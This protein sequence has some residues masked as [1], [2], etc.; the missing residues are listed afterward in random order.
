M[1]TALC[2][3]IVNPDTGS[4]APIQHGLADLGVDSQVFRSA[5][6]FLASSELNRTGCA[7]VDCRLPELAG[8]E[9]M[10]KLT[11][12]PL[13]IP[14]IAT[15]DSATVTDAIRAFNAGVFAFFE[16]PLQHDKIIETAYKAVCAECDRRCVENERLRRLSPLSQ[17]ESEVLELLTQGKNVKAIARDLGISA[18]TVEKHRASAL[19][20]CDFDSVIEVAHFLLATPT[21]VNRSPPTSANRFDSARQPLQP[22]YLRKSTYQFNRT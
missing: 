20:K 19:N 11:S 9:L 13:V 17:R 12:A 7:I 16:G 3:S 15:S 5:E 10:W 8:I 4:V 21:L 22:N 1:E 18:S 2:V 6:E 14:T